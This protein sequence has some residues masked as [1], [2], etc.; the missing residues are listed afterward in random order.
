MEDGNGGGLLS[1][2]SAELAE[3][4]ERAA[5]SV[6]RV[7]D[8]SRLTATG[9]IWSSDGIV[10]TTSHGVERDDDLVVELEDGKRVP[11]T[12]LGRDADTDLAV[13]RVAAADL[14]PLRRAAAGDV[15]VGNLALALGSP[16]AAGLQVS[17][18]LISAVQETETDGQSGYILYTDAMLAPGFSG[19]PLVD[20]VGRV[21]GIT[22]L[23][24]GRGRGVAIGTPVVEQVVGALLAD[25]HISRGYLGVRSQPVSLPPAL[26]E[27]LDLVQP[28]ALLVVSIEPGGPAERAGLTLGDIL[29]G[30]NGVPVEDGE[31]LRRR[32]R[33]H[34]AGEQAVLHTVRGGQL[35]V[36]TVALGA[37]E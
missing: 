33:A 7:D 30:L 13:L 37:Q 35:R 10:A 32:L 4:V 6:V 9:I 24:Y 5:V 2:L 3:L 34:R 22:N 18:G 25:G 12:L 29:V 16:G 11:A 1:Q 28:T 31:D 26:R 15:R 23:M 21:V 36:V 27:D 20:M 19:G 8:G 17:I 14:S